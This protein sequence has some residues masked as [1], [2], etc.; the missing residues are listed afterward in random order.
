MAPGTAQPAAPPAAPPAAQVVTWKVQTAFPA[1]S[2]AHI[3]FVELAKKIEAMSG[4]RFKWE[5]LPGGAI[6]PAFEAADAA[7]KGVIDAAGYV[8]AYFVGKHAGASLFGT[9]P[10]FG[11][12]A[13][14]LLAWEYYGGGWDL[15]QEL[16]Q[17]ELKLNLVGF[18]FGPIPTQ[19]L[20]WFRKPIRTADDMKGLKYRT[21]GLATEVY[22]QMGASV[23]SLPGGE[24]VPALE[25]GVIDAAEWNNTT[26]DKNLGF[27]QVTKY[28]Y[29][30]SYHQPVEY[31]EILV[32]KDKWDALSP[33]L[34]NLVRYAIMAES[35][36]MQ[37]RWIDLNS[38]DLI[39]IQK[40]GVQIF[41]TPPDILK[42]QL[43]AWDKII[44]KYTN[45]PQVGPF[46]K[47]VLDSQKAWASRVVPWK[48][49]IYVPNVYAYE[50]YWKK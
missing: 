10:S 20:G 6:V 23:V 29:L 26:D 2:L 7:G 24:I 45:D 50:K 22:S 28:Y 33:D 4:G 46:F 47:K 30:Q 8:P 3:S 38:K 17:K 49:Q 18:H 1:T 12:D 27:P 9:G 48:V 36:D 37:W 39:E 41:M 34:K 14:D 43:D 40:L 11:M 42:A 25:R 15:Y 5:V 13:N 31:L 35:A 32:N 19:P 16:L 21:V 44:D